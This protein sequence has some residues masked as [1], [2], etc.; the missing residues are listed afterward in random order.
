MGQRDL[1]VTRGFPSKRETSV[2]GRGLGDAG[3]IV[4]EGKYGGKPKRCALTMGKR[5]LRQ[6]L[7]ALLVDSGDFCTW[8]WVGSLLGHGKSVL[9]NS[10]YLFYPLN[11]S[12]SFSIT[13]YP[14]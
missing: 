3:C 8:H 5:S 11:A 9:P 1:L 7:N 12:Y 13:L 4:L 14:S 2:M 6:T 10:G